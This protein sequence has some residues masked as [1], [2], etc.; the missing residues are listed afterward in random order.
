MTKPDGAPRD[1]GL[2]FES[3]IAQQFTKNMTKTMTG[4]RE[5]DDDRFEDD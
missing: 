1:M 5:Y 2:G 4:E 3:Y